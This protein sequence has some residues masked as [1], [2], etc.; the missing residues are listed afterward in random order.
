MCLC[1]ICQYIALCPIGVMQRMQQQLLQVDLH[2]KFLLVYF[3]LSSAVSAAAS[4][5]FCTHPGR[6]RLSGI[7]LPING[8]RNV[9]LFVL[10]SVCR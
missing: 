6:E 8:I 9:V 2:L 5:H 3:T 4:V 10:L 7:Y 1:R